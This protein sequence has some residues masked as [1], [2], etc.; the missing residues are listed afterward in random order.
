MTD[1]QKGV[2]TFMS[3]GDNVAFVNALKADMYAKLADNQEFAA[4]ATDIE[5]YSKAYDAD[6]EYFS[7]VD[8]KA[9]E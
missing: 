6:P 2:Q 9:A 3:D 4:L 8:D 1:L 7:K 5:T